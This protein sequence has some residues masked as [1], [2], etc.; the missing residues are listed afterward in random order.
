MIKKYKEYIGIFEDISNNKKEYPELTKIIKEMIEQ[1][2]ENSGGEYK[3][4]IDSYIKSPDDIKIE[5]LIND[6]DIYD[7]YIKYRNEID[8]LL[9]DVRYFDIVP[10]EVNVLGLYDYII[11]GTTRSIT[12]IVKILSNE[13]TK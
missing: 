6:S 2:I 12:E 13:N 1:T 4:F 9:N 3:M 7:F 8:E 5:G 10:S 11:I